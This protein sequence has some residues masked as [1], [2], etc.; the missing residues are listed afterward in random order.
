M[1]HRLAALALLALA[2][3]PAASG[4]TAK[5][6][7][8]CFEVTTDAQGTY[9]IDYLHDLDQPKTGT[10]VAVWGWETK[11]ILAYQRGSVTLRGPGLLTGFF[12]EDDRVKDV[13][14]DTHFDPPKVIETLEKCPTSV[15][16]DEPDPDPLDFAKEPAR[17][18]NQFLQLGS[19]LKVSPG[20]YWSAHCAQ[21]DG[22]DSHDLN[23]D[24]T[25]RLPLDMRALKRHLG[26]ERGFTVSCWA[27]VSLRDPNPQPHDFSGDVEVLVRLR[28]FPFDK[29]EAREKALNKLEGDYWHGAPSSMDHLADQAH[30]AA[31]KDG[32][33]H[34]R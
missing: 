9:K 25:Q 14:F 2:V 20:E 17:L 1:R 28:Y 3:V 5:G 8:C 19:Q 7:N 6:L 22:A 29:L 23:A 21:V 10:Y 11:T 31:Q 34:C 12:A 13:G 26:I 32:K 24:V 30:G 18:R 16:L 15:D 4:S 27:S 33:R